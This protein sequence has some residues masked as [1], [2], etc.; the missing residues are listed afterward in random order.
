MSG[1][2]CSKLEVQKNSRECLYFDRAF[3]Y[4]KNPSITAGMKWKEVYQTLNDSF[5]FLDSLGKALNFPFRT[6]LLA[7]RYFLHYS[8]FNSLGTYPYEDVCIACIFLSSKVQETYKK[9]NK[10]LLAAVQAK[11][12]LF[13]SDDVDLSSLLEEHRKTVIGYER[14][15]LESIG[16]RFEHELPF[17]LFVQIAKYNA[18]T[19]G[20]E[21]FREGWKALRCMFRE[22]LPL[23]YHNA[24]LCLF[25]LHKF[26]H[27]LVVKSRLYHFAVS[28]LEIPQ[29]L[30]VQL[31]RDFLHALSVH[32]Q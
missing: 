30:W 26:E 5:L 11:N 1:K 29:Q 10:I 14:V 21:S 27:R 12:A 16:F 22:Y 24:I 6:V 31:G 20:D 25:C 7:Q 13:N 17:R 18:I 2:S 15:V 9:I 32:S 28:C 4:E 23:I 8:M 3:V 19:S